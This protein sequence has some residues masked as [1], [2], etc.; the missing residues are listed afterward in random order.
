M[1]T[2]ECGGRSVELG[3]KCIF[4]QE[5]RHVFGAGCIIFF[6]S[7]AARV[8]VFVGRRR[9]RVR[10]RVNSRASLTTIHTYKA[11]NDEINDKDDNEL[12]RGM[13]R[14]PG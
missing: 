11:N 10:A 9:H 1:S 13:R 3:K 12:D 8:T 4:K 14:T 5:K 6:L 7:H 2:A